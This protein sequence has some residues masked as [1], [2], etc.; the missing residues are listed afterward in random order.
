[1]CCTAYCQSR[2]AEPS[3]SSGRAA[4]RTAELTILLYKYA[5]IS[6][7]D[8]NMPACFRHQSFSN[9]ALHV[10]KYGRYV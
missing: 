4:G 2:Y 8:C 10:L 6:E 1:M 7:T 3:S 9:S 5:P